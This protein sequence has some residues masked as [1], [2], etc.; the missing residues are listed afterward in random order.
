VEICLTLLI[1]RRI[2]WRFSCKKGM[3][4]LLRRLVNSPI[5]FDATAR[6]ASEA[7]LTLLYSMS[8]L[9]FV[10]GLIDSEQKGSHAMSV[11]VLAQRIGLPRL[12]VDIRHDA[13]HNQLPSLQLL[14]HAAKQAL[15]WLEQNYWRAQAAALERTPKLLNKAIRDY[16]RVMKQAKAKKSAIQSCV[17]KVW[18][19]AQQNGP[20]AISDDLESSCFVLRL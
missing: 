2:W 13:T 4:C 17:A 11:N 6:R 15:S 5:N 9:R 12:F 8:L 18:A 1:Q 16:K 7:S 14:R 3:S 19:A 10:N 20:F